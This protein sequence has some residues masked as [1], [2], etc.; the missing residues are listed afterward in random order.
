MSS[1][2]KPGVK[3][4]CV[5]DRRAPFGSP[6]PF[7][8]GGVYV[9][10]DVN[11]L[12]N[13]KIAGVPQVDNVWFWKVERFRPLVTKTQSEDIEMFL[14]IASKAPSNMESTDA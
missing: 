1:W 11:D 14:R 6:S 3:C 2:A 8:R 12:G 7:A 10:E 5:D 13:I 4:V 9:V